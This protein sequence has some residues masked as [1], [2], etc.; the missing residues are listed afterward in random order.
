MLSVLV[1]IVSRD[2]PIS[3][4]WFLDPHFWG[5]LHYG[6]YPRCGSVCNQVQLVVAFFVSPYPELI[7]VGLKELR[8]DW[9]AWN[10]SM[11]SLP[12]RSFQRSS[13]SGISF[14]DQAPSGSTLAF[15]QL[16]LPPGK[17]IFGDLSNS[18]GSLP[19][20]TNQPRDVPFE[21]SSGFILETIA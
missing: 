20:P 15:S 17:K 11:C 21:P 12:F 18:S 19:I 1:N 3:T 2:G 16:V 14:W 8:L 6:R 9:N 5:I 7:A 10:P 4:E 13:G